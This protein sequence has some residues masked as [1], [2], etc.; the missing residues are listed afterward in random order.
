MAE[1]GRPTLQTPE[2]VEEILSKLKDGWTLREVC[3]ADHMPAA[4]TVRSWAA[5]TKSEFSEQ[6][7]RA[8]ELGYH[9][10]ADEILDIADDGLNDWVERQRDNGESYTVVDHEHIS[11]SKL[12]VDT[13]KWL[14]SKALPKLYGDKLA[15]EATGKD[16]GP[17]KTED[18]TEISETDAARRIAYML[19]RAMAKKNEPTA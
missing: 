1:P 5:D 8:R 14:L 3:N 11:R 6:Y 19:G 12:R 9:R 15:V 16:G 10:M 7:V 13:R 17:I 18:V 2:I 4:S